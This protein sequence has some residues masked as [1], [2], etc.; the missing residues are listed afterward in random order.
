[1]RLSTAIEARTGVRRVWERGGG[2][3]LLFAFGCELLLVALHFVAVC[4]V[5]TVV[6]LRRLVS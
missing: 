5:P 2:G 1:M 4:F 3:G 6:E